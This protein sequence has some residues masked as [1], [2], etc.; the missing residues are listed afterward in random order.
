MQ[1]L[2]PDPKGNQGLGHLLAFVGR[3]QGPRNGIR[4]RKTL[5]K[6]EGPCQEGIQ[7]RRNSRVAN[8]LGPQ[9]LRVQGRNRRSHGSSQAGAEDGEEHTENHCQ[10]VGGPV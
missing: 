6:G 4:R 5:A 9:A 2:P 7:D 1:C 8:H 3:A 10:M